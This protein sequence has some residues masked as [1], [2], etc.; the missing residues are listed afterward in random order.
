M[1][2]FGLSL[3]SKPVKS[4]YGIGWF[5]CHIHI[6][7]AWYPYSITTWAH[8]LWLTYIC[9]YIYLSLCLWLSLI[10]NDQRIT[11]PSHGSFMNNSDHVDLQQVA[12]IDKFPQESFLCIG[13]VFDEHWH[14]RE[15]SV[16]LG[17]V[18]DGPCLSRPTTLQQKVV[19][20]KLF[21]TYPNMICVYIS[22]DCNHPYIYV[23]WWDSP[24]MIVGGGRCSWE[25]TSSCFTVPTHLQ[26]FSW[27]SV[28]YTHFI[29]MLV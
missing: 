28:A 14:R 15:V 10:I 21:E 11:G 7:I 13:N 18:D 6:I 24:M 9:I 3:Q 29:Q 4:Q 26:L 8:C 22:I 23:D 16:D 12:I 27:N 20:C 5:P 25:S 19:L 17:W 1:D 2:L